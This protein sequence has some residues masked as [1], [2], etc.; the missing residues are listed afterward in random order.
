MKRPKFVVYEAKDGW[1]W[2]LVA[3]N[4]RIIA[5][6]GEAY[7]RKHGAQRAVTT[8]IGEVEK[9]G[10]ARMI[11]RIKHQPDYAASAHRYE[12]AHARNS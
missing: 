1:R 5:D 4:G 9:I 10:H 2:R 7:T 8:T 3:A 6:S 11:E 12:T